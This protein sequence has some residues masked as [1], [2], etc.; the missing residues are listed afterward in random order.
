MPYPGP[1]PSPK[2]C[3]EHNPNPNPNPN[4]DPNPNPN[5]TLT[6]APNLA[7]TQALGLALALALTLTLSLVPLTLVRWESAFEEAVRKRTPAVSVQH[8]LFLPLSSGYDS[9]AIHLVIRPTTTSSL[10]AD[11][12]FDLTA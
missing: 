2:P 1:D 11:D 3:P 10:L 5:P 12:T 4:P 6:P 8:G 7:L 9:G